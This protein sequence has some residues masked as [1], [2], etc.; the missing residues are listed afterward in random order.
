MTERIAEFDPR[1][2]ERL[3][4]VI[5]RQAEH[6]GRLLVRQQELLATIV[7]LTN[8]TPF[9][10]EVKGWESQRSAMVAEV[11]TLRARVAELERNERDVARMRVVVDAADAWA[12]AECG[13]KGSR[14]ALLDAIDWLHEL[15][16]QRLV[17]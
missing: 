15:E 1:P 7:R 10:D 8:E 12:E 5:D 13:D 14:D 3:E 17:R 9:P 4:D 6:I 16:R 11:G 2:A